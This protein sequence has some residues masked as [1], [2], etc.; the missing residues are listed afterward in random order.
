MARYCSALQAGQAYQ[1]RGRPPNISLGI[2]PEIQHAGGNDCE[3]LSP[4]GAADHA[5]GGT[6][7]GRTPL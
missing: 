5:L 7:N 4:V 6:P 3:H 2:D 1:R